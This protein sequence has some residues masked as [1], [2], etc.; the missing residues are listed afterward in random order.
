MKLL[1]MEVGD[2]M[3]VKEKMTNIANAVRSLNGSIEKLSLDAISAALQVEKQNVDDAFD[4]IVNKGVSVPD[5]STSSAL[6]GLIDSIEGGGGGADI[7]EEAFKFTGDYSDTF[8]NGKWTWFLNSYK[9]KISTENLTNTQY[10]FNG[11]AN[12]EDLPFDF[13]FS[14]STYTNHN[15]MFF[16]CKKLKNIGKIKNLYPANLE[17]LFDGCHNL[18]ELP[19]FENLNLDRIYTYRY[20]DLSQMFRQCYSLREIPE[21]LLKQLYTP[22]ATSSGYVLWY[23]GFNSC[24]TLNEIKGLNPQTGTVTSNMFTYAFSYCNMLK[25]LIFATQEDGTPYVVNWKNQVID[26]SEHSSFAGG[27][28]YATGAFESSTG[29][30]SFPNILNYNSGITED[31]ILRYPEDYDRLK[32]DPDWIS[33]STAYSRYNHDSAV[34]TI[35]SLP[36]TSAY[37]ASAGGTNTIKFYGI[38]GSATDGGAINTLTEAEIAVAAAK[39]WTVTL[40]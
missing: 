11:S 22:L 1:L 8:Q 32:N 27:I 14:N 39:G 17:S 20:A 30:P 37:L 26:L 18:R 33:A 16:G 21:D 23:Q 36:D 31:K 38:V 7:P 29:K 3:S 34:N 40:V 5:G 19:I 13:N 25:N 28:G 24:Y 12:L 35:N 2:S 6:A 10:M 4:A 9:N 15:N